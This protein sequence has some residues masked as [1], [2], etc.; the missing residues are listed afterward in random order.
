MLW[1]K[2]G[3]CSLPAVSS[4]AWHPELLEGIDVET[5][6]DEEDITVAEIKPNPRGNV[7]F[8]LLINQCFTW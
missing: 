7:C 6:E 2:W 5:I 3:T 8:R 4:K 1:A